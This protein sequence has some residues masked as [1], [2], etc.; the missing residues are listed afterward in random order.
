MLT[1]NIVHKTR[2]GSCSSTVCI[3]LALA[4]AILVT[5]EV[6]EGHVQITLNFTSF[7]DLHLVKVLEDLVPA[8]QTISFRYR[9]LSST[10]LATCGV[11]VTIFFLVY[12][13]GK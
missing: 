2:A 4:C 7:G 3:S 10:F 1:D 11:K 6:W 9:R 5:F 8:D 13:T 12:P